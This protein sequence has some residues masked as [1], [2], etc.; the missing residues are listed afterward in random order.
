MVYIYIY[1]LTAYQQTSLSIIVYTMYSFHFLI[2]RMQPSLSPFFFLCSRRTVFFTGVTPGLTRLSESTWKPARTGSWFWPATTWTCLLCLFLRSTSTGVTGQFKG[3][4]S[5]ICSH[6]WIIFFLFY[7]VKNI[8]LHFAVYWRLL[9]EL[10]RTAPSREEAK[11][12]P[13]MPCSS[14][15]A[16]ECS[17]KISRFSTGPDSRVGTK[18]EKCLYYSLKI[19]LFTVRFCRTAENLCNNTTAL[20]SLTLYRHQRLQKQQR[21]LWAAVSFPRQRRAHLRLRPRHAGRGQPQLPW[22]RRLPA[23]LGANHIKEHPLVGRD[24]PQ[25][26]NQALR[27]PRPH[28]ERHRPQLWLPRRWREGL[29]PHLFQRHPLWQHP[30]DQRWR[31]G[32]QDCGWQ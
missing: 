14:G 2:Q 17:W 7:Q 6:A 11:T 20:T 13:L 5:S 29:Q 9:L 22:L 19:D 1:E 28:E 4:P 27:G 32:P 23:V 10:M 31:H 30:A 18:L 26:A 12:M 21:R 15:L 25:R 16:L 8:K 24:E 3:V